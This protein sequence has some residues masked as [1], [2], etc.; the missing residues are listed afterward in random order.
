MVVKYLANIPDQL[1][2]ALPGSSMESAP[3]S[4]SALMDSQRTVS[5][6]RSNIKLDNTLI[7][8]TE[9]FDPLDHPIRTVVL[10][11]DISGFTALSV[12]WFVVPHV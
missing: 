10:F 2:N 7:E 4:L 11:A 3:G 6:R 8:T 12:S 1:T 5:R 9:S